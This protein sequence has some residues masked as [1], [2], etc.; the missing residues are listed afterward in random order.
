MVRSSNLFNPNEIYCKI[1]IVGK[2]Y[3]NP[4]TFKG[5]S[6]VGKSSL[7]E[8]YTQN[9]FASDKLAT[10][11]I[12]FVALEIQKEDIKMNLNIMDTAG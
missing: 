8:R 10:I 12:E 3:I 6:S 4:I 11:G 1:V 5:S 9:S 2:R 7:L